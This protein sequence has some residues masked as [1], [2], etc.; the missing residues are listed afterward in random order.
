M[1]ESVRRIAATPQVP[2]RML[3]GFGTLGSF[4]WLLAHDLIHPIVIYALELYLS[5]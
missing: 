1:L 3:V 2:V 4:L 5:F